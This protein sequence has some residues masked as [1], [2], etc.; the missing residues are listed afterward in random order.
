MIH[1]R[2]MSLVDKSALAGRQG[3]VDSIVSCLNC[4]NARANG[5]GKGFFCVIFGDVYIGDADRLC[6]EFRQNENLAAEFL[7]SEGA[8]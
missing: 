8:A 3:A 4:R 7:E 5:T 1:G 2:R 6:T